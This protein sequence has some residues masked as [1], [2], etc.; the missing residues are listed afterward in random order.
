VKANINIFWRNEAWRIKA[1]AA[2]LKWQRG[3]T[4]GIGWQKK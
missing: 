1:K 3:V 2:A 4:C